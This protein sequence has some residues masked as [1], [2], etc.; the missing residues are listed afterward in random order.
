MAILHRF[1][2]RII[3]RKRSV[4]LRVF[5]MNGDISEDL[6][7]RKC[8]AIRRNLSRSAHSSSLMSCAHYHFVTFVS[9]EE[10]V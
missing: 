5:E 7:P 1:S 3:T 8:G 9:E 2:P 6:R 4:G 10:A